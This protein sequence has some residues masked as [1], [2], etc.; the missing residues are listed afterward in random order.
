MANDSDLF[1]TR[2]E[3]KKAGFYPVDGNQLR[4]G[5]EIYVPLYAGKMIWFF[6]HRA[7]SVAVNEN[8]LKVTGSSKNTTLQEHQNPNF[9][10][11]PQYF[12]DLND[13]NKKVNSDWMIVFRDITNTTNERTFISAIIPKY[14]CNHKLPILIPENGFEEEYKLFA[15]IILSNLSSFMFDFVTRQKTQS[16]SMT[17]FSVEQLPVIPP[18]LFEQPLGNTTVA[19]FI[20]EHVLHLTYTAW[21]M[22]PFAKDMGYDGEPFIWDEEDRRHRKAK[23]DALFFNLYEISE[24]DADYILSTFPIVKKHDEAEHGRFLTRD[25]ILAYMRA[26]KAGDTEVIV[27]V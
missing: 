13:V 2:V 26:L 5:K 16:T 6:D 10:L 25:L 1:K 11:E 23:L 15:P 24:E 14:A 17:W 3:L 12:V 20:K 22:Q 19:N 7:S 18:Q 4:K 21:D 9:N 27:K 8:N